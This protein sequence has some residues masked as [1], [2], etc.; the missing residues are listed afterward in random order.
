MT[1]LCFAGPLP[2]PV[3]GFSS[4]CGMMLDLLKARMPVEV[5]NRAPRPTARAIGV[6]QQLIRPLR[7]VATCAGKRDTALYLALSGGRGQYID[8][9]YVLIS[10]LFRRP[11]YI[12]HH[13]YVYINSPSRLNRRFFALVRNEN[14]IVLSPKMGL[15]LCAVY[16]LDPRRVCVVSNAAFY[17]GDDA[18][19]AQANEAAPVHLG[20][21]SNITFEKG[22]VEFFAVL[23]TLTR[24][25]IDYRAHIAGPVAAE[26]RQTFDKL[27]QSTAHVHYAGPVYGDAKERFYRQLDI[28]LFPTRYAN[29]AE[30]L[31]IYEAM[32]R[33]V[34]VIACDRGAIAEM[35]CDG[36]GLVLPHESPVDAA[37]AH[38]EHFSNDRHALFSAKR[39]SM[40][41]AQQMLSSS[42]SAL[43]NLVACMQATSEPVSIPQ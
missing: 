25:G 26:A 15:S 21:L 33:G 1:R 17:G 13:S 40:Q 20:F 5:F 37:A 7:Y 43:E 8:L 39:A 9:I 27:L 18:S 11:V 12:H 34:H 23:A 28:F 42:K 38:I 2:P 35:L 36:A 41:Q 14:H 16:G 31:V 19:Q 29:E 24:R 32:L 22:I 4:V 3:N 6:L 10:K 30:P